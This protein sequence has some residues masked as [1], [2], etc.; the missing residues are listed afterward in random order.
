MVVA[1]S[2][3][4]TKGAARRAARD[5]PG[6]VDSQVPGPITKRAISNGPCSSTIVP[7][8][9]AIYDLSPP[10]AIH[11]AADCYS[12]PRG[13]G[14]GDEGGGRAQLG[15]MSD[16][17]IHV[18][19]HR[20]AATL[21]S[22][23]CADPP[24]LPLPLALTDVPCTMIRYFIRETFIQEARVTYDPIRIDLDNRGIRIVYRSTGNPRL[25]LFRINV[26]IHAKGNLFFATITDCNLP[27]SW[28]GSIDRPDQVSRA[29]EERIRVDR[30]FRI[31]VAFRA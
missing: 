18:Q 10:D 20:V 11:R 8:H 9:A 19:V 12:L 15:A 4:D 25:R 3:D 29:S 7:R 26:Q 28:P 30:L 27:K 24:S 2:F 17:F 22:R 14:A 1:W 23:E 6:C 21:R 31:G 5:S 13:R 16:A